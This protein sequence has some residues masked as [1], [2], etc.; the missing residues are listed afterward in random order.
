MLMSKYL[1]LSVV[2]PAALLLL[3]ACNSA[4]P[5]LRLVDYD[6]TIRVACIGDSITYGAGVENREANNYPAVM[7]R[8]MGQKFEVRNFGVSGA[9]LLA[10]GDNPYRKCPQYEEAARFQPDVVIILLGTNDSKPQNWEHSKEFAGDLNAMLDHFSHLPSHPKI[11]LCLPVPAYQVQ[12][13]I[14]DDVIVNGVI[15]AIKKSAQSRGIP[16]I[17][18]YYALGNRP[19]LFPDKIHPNAKGAELIARTV[20]DALLAH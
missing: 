8:L 16:I 4:K 1:K 15:P 20:Q 2:V 7:E 12:W 3:T 11:W 10:K 19:D 9:T 5:T 6:R 18:L 13:G 17:D 14:N